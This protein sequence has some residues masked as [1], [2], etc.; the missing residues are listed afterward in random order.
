[1]V[2]GSR[3]HLLTPGHPRH[4]VKE[5]QALSTDSGEGHWSPKTQS[6]LACSHQQSPDASLLVCPSASAARLLDHLVPRSWSL[7][8]SAH[9]YSESTWC[10]VAS[11][12]SPNPPSAS[13]LSSSS[14][15][16]SRGALSRLQHTSRTQLSA[17][18]MFLSSSFIY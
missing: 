10:A 1:M 13:S 12:L 8:R 17:V 18:M 11:C 16:R 9:S 7:T 14:R 15:S 4:P 5:P 3:P 6:L 2:S